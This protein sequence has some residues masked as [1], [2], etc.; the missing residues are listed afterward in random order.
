MWKKKREKRL[1]KD[2]A[3]KKRKAKA[4]ELKRVKRR[5]EEREHMMG[6]RMRERELEG[7]AKEAEMY[8]DWEQ[9]EEQFHLA[10]Q[11][12]RT[13]RRLVKRREKPIDAVAKNI[14]LVQQ[15]EDG[16]SVGIDGKTGTVLDGQRVRFDTKEPFHVLETLDCDDLEALRIDIEEYLAMSDEKYVAFWTSM[17]RLCNE[18]IRFASTPIAVRKTRS[19]YEGDVF[20]ILKECRGRSFEG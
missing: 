16:L 10:Q 13:K 19:Y 18:A 3:R 5:K 2:E 17:L 9:K 11:R 12:E 4:E 7:R 6:E 8:A 14:L 15:V 1:T 20:D